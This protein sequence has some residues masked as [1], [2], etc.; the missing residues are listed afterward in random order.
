MPPKKAAKATKSDD[1]VEE[2]KKTT[3]KGKKEAPKADVVLTGDLPQFDDF[4]DGLCSWKS[5]LEATT[6]QKYF[7]NLYN[8]LKGEY[9][10][11]AVTTFLHLTLLNLI[12]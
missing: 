5:S 8:F 6:K 3:K 12:L 7:Q 11:K 10:S 9:S 1:M 2:E 4:V